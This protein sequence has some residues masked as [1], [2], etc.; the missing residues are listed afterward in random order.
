MPVEEGQAGPDLG[1]VTVTQ[2]TTLFQARDL[3]ILGQFV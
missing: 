2:I 1:I 3:I